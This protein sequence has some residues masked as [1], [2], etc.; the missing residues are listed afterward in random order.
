MTLDPNSASHPLSYWNVN[1]T[2]HLVIAG[3]GAQVLLAN[4]RDVL[5]MRVVA[6]L[7]ARIA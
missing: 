1:S 6:P 3:R 4:R 2:G 5:H 7:E